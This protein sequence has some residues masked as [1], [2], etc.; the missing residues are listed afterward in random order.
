MVLIHHP[1]SCSLKVSVFSFHVVVHVHVHVDVG[2]EAKTGSTVH[3]RINSTLH[4]EKL[5]SNLSS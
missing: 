4:L 1:V 5:D 3:K 2:G